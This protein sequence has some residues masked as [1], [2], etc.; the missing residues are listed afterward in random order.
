MK[1]DCICIIGVIIIIVLLNSCIPIKNKYSNIPYTTDE[2]ELYDTACCNHI[3]E[4]FEAYYQ[5]YRNYDDVAYM[6]KYL[7]LLDSAL[8]HCTNNES[9]IS[10]K[11]DSY[12]T[13]GLYQECVDYMR[14]IPDSL[15]EYSYTR[16]FYI[17]SALS[18]INQIK[19]DTVSRNKNNEEILQKIT[20]YWKKD[21]RVENRMNEDTITSQELAHFLFDNSLLRTS[22]T[23]AML[24]VVRAR[25]EDISILQD[26]ITHFIIKD[27][28]H[29]IIT[30]NF[31][32]GLL[33][34]LEQMNER[35]N[36]HFERDII[37]NQRVN[38]K[39]KSIR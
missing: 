23:M 22:E 35:K 7:N 31:W 27:D 29:S 20:D 6:Y 5:L 36:Y 11:Y 34:L 32:S 17:N 39:D 33:R 1:R 18:V 28:M 2:C 21:S 19:G 26:E 8:L 13:I 16:V 9:L 14:G 25:Y 15:F 38:N 3:Y 4:N 30:N 12:M 37:L 10:R 24:Y